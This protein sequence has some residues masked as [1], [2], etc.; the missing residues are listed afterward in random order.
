MHSNFGC[1]FAT[2]ALR[3]AKAQATRECNTA[4]GGAY[5]SITL[6]YAPF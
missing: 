1:A 4:K 6:P 2:E 5:C 3:V